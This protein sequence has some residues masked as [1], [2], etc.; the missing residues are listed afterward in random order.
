MNKTPRH[1]SDTR[2]QSDNK[3]EEKNLIM[4]KNQNQVSLPSIKMNQN[5]NL[6]DRKINPAINNLTAN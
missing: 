1:R 4:L 3:I 2:P 5:N 6:N